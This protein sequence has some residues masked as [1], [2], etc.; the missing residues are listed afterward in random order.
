MRAVMA[1]CVAL[2]SFS[3]QAQSNNCDC[4][5][6]TAA[7]EASINVVPTTST[8]GS[9]GADLK[10]RSTAPQ[11]SKVDYYVD[12]TPYFTI[13]SQGNQGEDRVFGQKPITR[14]NISDISCHV[15]RREGESASSGN[16]TK[17]K[18]GSQVT[19]FRPDGDAGSAVTNQLVV[20]GQSVG[21]LGNGQS[22]TIYLGTG[23]HTVKNTRIYQ[24][25]W[26]G[27]CTQSIQVDGASAYRYEVSLVRLVGTTATSASEA[28]CRLIAR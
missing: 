1:S 27:E 7:C 3:A 20:D 21:N 2:L 13:L 26:Q 15:C 10:I 28:S 4:Q 11:C 23:S 14:A 24:G 6:F 16:Q 12:G 18:G 9:Y 25:A 17:P 8:K 5:Q 19:L 22:L